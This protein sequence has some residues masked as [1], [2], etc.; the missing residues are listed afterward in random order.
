MWSKRIFFGLFWLAVGTGCGF[1]PVYWQDKDAPS[2]LEKTAQVEIT[3][4]PEESGRILT[5]ALKD[6][7]NPKNMD[8]PKNYTLSVQIKETIDKDQGILGDKTSTRATF[9]LKAVYQLKT[10]KKVLLS[11]TAQAIS[12]YN[13]L[14]DPYSTVTAEQAVRDRLLKALA[15]DISLQITSYLKSEEETH[16]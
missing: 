16:Q 11:S 13:I 1:T 4:I 2:F 12:S 5:Q 8:A 6:N 9:Y 14:T 10:A 7:L 15:K 3:P